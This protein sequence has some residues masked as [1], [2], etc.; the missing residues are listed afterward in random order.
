MKAALS[1][2][3]LLLFVSTTTYLVANSLI[4]LSSLYVFVSAFS[5]AS[6]IVIIDEDDP[7][8]S[9]ALNVLRGNGICVV[10]GTLTC[11][12]STNFAKLICNF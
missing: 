3:L 4:T 8:Y 2:I 1:L 10:T 6:P 9:Y 11:N 5:P 12:V 7:V